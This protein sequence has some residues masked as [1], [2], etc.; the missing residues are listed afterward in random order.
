M[1]QAHDIF[2]D[3]SRG[4]QCTANAAIAIAM[5]ILH[6]PPTWTKNLIDTILLIGD[7]LY[8]KSILNRN[9]LHITEINREF[10]LINCT[11]ILKF[12]ETSLLF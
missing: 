12:L 4:K 1:H 5:C 7:A 6:D 8:V 11:Q 10:L 9:E 3:F 2:S